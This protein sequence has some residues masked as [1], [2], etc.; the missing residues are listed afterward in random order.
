MSA[1][2]EPS[3]GPPSLKDIKKATKRA[4][5]GVEIG[6]DGRKTKSGGKDLKSTLSR[7]H[8]LEE[9][10]RTDTSGIMLE[11]PQFE[12]D[13]VTKSQ[14]LRDQYVFRVQMECAQYWLRQSVREHQNANH[15]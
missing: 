4:L 1:K 8:R 7:L 10:V 15:R 13:E 12:S 2:K 11:R 14:L 5:D 6:T 3:T 9:K